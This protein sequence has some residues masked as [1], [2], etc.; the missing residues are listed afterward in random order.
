[1]KKFKCET[2]AQI[3]I[4]NSHLIRCIPKNSILFTCYSSV[5]VCVS[6]CPFPIVCRFFFLFKALDF[7]HMYACMKMWQMFEKEFAVKWFIHCM[8]S[9]QCNVHKHILFYLNMLW[10]FHGFPQRIVNEPTS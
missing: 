8:E 1:M 2:F 5:C 7:R 3:S 9:T 4:M 10:L 6:L